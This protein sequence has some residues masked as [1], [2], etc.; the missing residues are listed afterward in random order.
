MILVP[1]FQDGLICLFDTSKSDEEEAL[2]SV[3]NCE[4]SVVSL[5]E[6]FHLV[7]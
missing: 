2:D 1:F 5:I 3:L 7:S 6:V 4:T